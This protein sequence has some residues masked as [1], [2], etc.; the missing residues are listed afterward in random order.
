MK[1]VYSNQGLALV[2]HFKNLL[3]SQG[4]P[5]MIKNE[6]LY[7]ASG[8]LP[9]IA[10]WPEIWVNESQYDDA[11]SIIDQALSEE[12]TQGS[13]WKCPHCGEFHEPQFAACWNCGASRPPED[14]R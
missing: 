5:C 9:P 7:M 1:R 10:V 2:H 4:I 3:E 11:K 8:E 6:T 14:S 13:P 12:I